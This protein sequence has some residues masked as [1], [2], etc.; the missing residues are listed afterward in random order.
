MIAN[1]PVTVQIRDAVRAAWPVRTARRDRLYAFGFDAYRL[2]PA[3]GAKAPVAAGEISGV[4]GKLHIDD[5]NRI[6]R[7][8]DWTQIRNGAPN[9]L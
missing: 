3:L 8:L 4:T 9:S 1:D 5:Q 2:M 7:D 6:H